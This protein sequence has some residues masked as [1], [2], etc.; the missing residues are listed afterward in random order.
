M[1]TTT[2]V[3]R[4]EATRTRGEGT[5]ATDAPPSEWS[6]HEITRHTGTTS[7]TLRHYDKGGLLP[8]S[9]IG[10]HVYRDYDTGALLRLQRILLLRRPGLGLKP[11]GG[12]LDGREGERDA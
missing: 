4:D 11:S 8:P 6:M 12:A 2:G 10:A 3:A 1:A 7:R 5:A 9:R